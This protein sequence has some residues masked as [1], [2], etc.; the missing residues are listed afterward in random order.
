VA[1]LRLS[2][3]AR[4]RTTP[5]IEACGSSLATGAQ[6]G[7][8]LLEMIIVVAVIGLALG[9]VLTRG[10][11]RSPKLEMQAA[12]NAVTQ[13]LRVARSRAIVTNRPV[14]FAVLPPLQ[15]FRT[16]ADSPIALPPDVSI[17][18][19]EPGDGIRSRSIRFDGDGSATGG[20]IQMAGNRWTALIEV[21]WLTGRVSFAQVR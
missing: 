10:P 5:M 9:L 8:T 12:V 11:V 17:D 19:L 20:R 7:F 2:T 15:A 14:H 3:P 6:A 16:D 18:L 21:D 4:E 13:G 1:I